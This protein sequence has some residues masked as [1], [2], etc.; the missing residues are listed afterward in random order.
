M[1][2]KEIIG[3]YS[4]FFA[5]IF[6]RLQKLGIDI[7]GYPLSHLGIKIASFEE[8]E[9]LRDE[10]K[11]YSVAFAENEHNGRPIGDIALKDVIE[12]EGKVF[13]SV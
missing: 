7:S 2:I 13:I 1:E 6:D 11:K 4:T 5:D 8:Y 12:Q 3:D 10:I 9:H